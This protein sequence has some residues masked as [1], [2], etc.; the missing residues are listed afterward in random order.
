MITW[1]LMLAFGL[2]G[3]RVV[4][5]LFGIRATM[6]LVLRLRLWSGSP[7]GLDQSCQ[8]GRLAEGQAAQG[9]HRPE[10]AQRMK[11]FGQRQQAAGHPDYQRSGFITIHF[12]PQML[13]L[14]VGQA[15]TD[16]ALTR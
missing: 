16:Y 10:N 8:E 6:P 2:W 14:F 1:L 9:S 7:S 3:L 13:S 5:R 12:V 15:V 11:S 4:V